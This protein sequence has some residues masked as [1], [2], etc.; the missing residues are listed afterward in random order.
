[1]HN[2]GPILVREAFDQVLLYHV[3]VLWVNLRHL[4]QICG[5]LPYDSGV[6]YALSLFLELI[7]VGF[8]EGQH[9]LPQ[10]IILGAHLSVQRYYELWPFIVVYHVESETPL[11]LPDRFWC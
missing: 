4:L 10:R 5:Q 11:V 9:A 1:M 2:L 7:L 3:L 8:R 6:I